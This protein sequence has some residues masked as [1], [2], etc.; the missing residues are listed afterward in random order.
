MPLPFFLPFLIKGGIVAAKLLATK[1]A[2]AKTAVVVTKTAIAHYGTA[3]TAA[4]I[5]AGLVCIGGVTWSV[6]NIT[7][8]HNAYKY[9]L[10]ND[11]PSAAGEISALA[12]SVKTIGTTD[13]TTDLRHW[14]DAGMPL[15][16][17]LTELVKE[18]NALASE[19]ART[20]RR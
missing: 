6:E 15:D 19:A 2:V 5:A 7:R 20:A 4:G 9:L 10:A 11:Y 1:A 12:K 16:H 14:L 17:S 13:F 8:A 18:A 3:Q